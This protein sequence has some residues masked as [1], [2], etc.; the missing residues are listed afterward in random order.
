MKLDKPFR[1]ATKLSLDEWLKLLN[2][3]DSE[4]YAFTTYEF[5]TDSMR[6]EYLSSIQNRTEKEVIDLLR[7]F[8]ITSGSLG[9]D[10]D[11]FM[12]LMNFLE[13]DKATY[14]KLMEMEYYKRLQ[15][16]FLGNTPI[17]E[18]NTWIIDLLPNNPKLALEALN[19]YFI[20]HIQVLPDGRVNGLNDAMALIRAKFIQEPNSTILQTLDPYQFEHVVDSLFMEMGYSTVLTR[21]TY[22]GGVDIIATKNVA[23]S[24]EKVLVQCNI[25]RKIL[26][27]KRQELYLVWF[28]IIKQTKV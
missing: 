10:E 14:E 1:D 26:E 22:D 3:K 16:G 28:L 20:A 21:R 24:I 6:D 17:W 9:K 23:G 27:L 19:A 8:L 7:H 12:F 11:S 2:S 18:G 13:N 4:S 15:E 25:L 5:P